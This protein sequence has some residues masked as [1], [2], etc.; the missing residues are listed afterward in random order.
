MHEKIISIDTHVPVL[1]GQPGF[2]NH[3]NGSYGSNVNREDIAN[4]NYQVR[5]I[6]DEIRP[7]SNVTKEGK[8]EGL[9]WHWD[10]IKGIIPEYN[11]LHAELAEHMKI[12]LAE[13]CMC[14]HIV[15]MLLWAQ[16]EA[17]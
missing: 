10:F 2:V 3:L 13:A 14:A 15:M 5:G 8:G 4:G 7:P 16:K 6:V 12:A 1:G 11:E 17:D 9:A